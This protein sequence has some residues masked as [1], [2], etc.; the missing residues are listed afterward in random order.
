MIRT[1]DA[2]AVVR[3]QLERVEDALAALRRDVLPKNRRNFEILSEGYVE[4]IALLR[5]EIDGYLGLAPPTPAEQAA[6]VVRS[7]DLDAQ[8]FVLRQRP[9][10]EPDLLCEFGAHLEE[11]VTAALG[12][13]VLVTGILD[14]SP[15]T[16]KEKMEVEKI[17]P[18][19]PQGELP[20]TRGGP[21]AGRESIAKPA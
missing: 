15:K 2:L 11:T 12:R 8:T 7:I 18:L 20:S 21:G 5:R 4:Q 17:D 3:R 19:P 6:G 9:G 16:Q 1:D 14:K 10:Q 13:P